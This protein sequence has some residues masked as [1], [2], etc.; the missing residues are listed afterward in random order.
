[1]STASVLTVARELSASATNTLSSNTAIVSPSSFT[2]FN[3]GLLTAV[4]ILPGFITFLGMRGL[5]WLLFG[6]S[7]HR[8]HLITRR[9]E[10][11]NAFLLKVE[12]SSKP[13]AVNNKAQ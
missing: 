12:T 8:Q 4:H 5:G 2:W 11:V 10:I 1:M 13:G 9:E 7:I 3:Y 6:R